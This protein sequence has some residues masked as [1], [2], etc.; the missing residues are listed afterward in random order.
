[1]YP[2]NQIRSKLVTMSYIETRQYLLAL[3]DQSCL[4]ISNMTSADVRFETGSTL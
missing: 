4:S 3:K 1:M 2:L